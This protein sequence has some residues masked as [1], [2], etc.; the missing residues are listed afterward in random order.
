[1]VDVPH[2]RGDVGVAEHCLH[3]RQRER[4]D[5]GRTERMAQIVKAD[6]GETGILQRPVVAT[7]QQRVVLD[8]ADLIGEHEVVGTS[9]LLTLPEPRQRGRDLRT[10]GT[11]RTRLDLGVLMVALAPTVALRRTW[12]RSAAKS[13]SAQRNARSSPW[14][15]PVWAAVR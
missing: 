14:R 4:L 5:R 10:I 2:R 13:T 3:V 8:L 12:I 6:A 9:E 1:V 15:S 11:E 7:P